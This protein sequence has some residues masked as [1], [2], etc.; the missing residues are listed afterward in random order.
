[1]YELHFGRIAPRIATKNQWTCTSWW[2]R[3]RSG[4]MGLA[5]AAS[6]LP[7][8]ISDAGRDSSFRQG[9][10]GRAANLRVGHEQG[11]ARPRD[12]GD[13]LPPG[14]RRHRDSSSFRNGLA[15]SD[16]SIF[17][18]HCSFCLWRHMD[19]SAQFQQSKDTRHLSIDRPG[20]LVFG[21]SLEIWDFSD[22]RALSSFHRCWLCYLGLIGF[23]FWRAIEHCFRRAA[24]RDH[25]G[26]GCRPAHRL[27][28]PGWTC[29]RT[30]SA[31]PPSQRGADLL[32]TSSFKTVVG[33]FL[34]A[35]LMKERREQYHRRAFICLIH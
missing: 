1:M 25:L 9:H 3:Q 17:R 6:T 2:C 28:W 24:D 14:S 20:G 33:A 11:H 27:L 13:R 7:W 32:S 30:P 23:E 15:A 34:L 31:V 10:F 12:M 18:T 29:A 26:T 19:G 4:V 8:S 21:P 35:F 16:Q 22:S 5:L